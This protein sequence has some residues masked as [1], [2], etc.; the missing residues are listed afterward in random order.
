MEAVEPWMAPQRWGWDGASGTTACVDPAR[1]RLAVL[2][3]QRAVA[4][5]ND[6][7]DDFWAAIA[8]TPWG[9]GAAS[10]S[11]TV[12]HGDRFDRHDGR[13]RRCHRTPR[14][15]QPPPRAPP[16]RPDPPHQAKDA[17]RLIVFR[18]SR[19]NVET[20]RRVVVTAVV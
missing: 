1:D 3:T 18:A 2:L 6:R 8:A 5:P 20:E 17:Y 19:V 11:P 13:P 9:W 12:R 7:F 15:H 4:G 14:P 10:R 16:C